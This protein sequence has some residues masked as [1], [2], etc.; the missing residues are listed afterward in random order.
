MKPEIALMIKKLKTEQINNE[1]I[2]IHIAYE[3]MNETEDIKKLHDGTW[4]DYLPSDAIEDVT[5]MLED[6]ES[7]EDIPDNESINEDV[8]DI[9]AEFD[10]VIE[11]RKN[12]DIQIA[13]MQNKYANLKEQLKKH[14]NPRPEKIRNIKLLLENNFEVT[15]SPNLDE[16]LNSNIWKLQNGKDPR[17]PKS[18]LEKA[19]QTKR[20]N[21]DEIPLILQR[22]HDVNWDKF[23]GVLTGASDRRNIMVIDFD[24]KRLPEEIKEL[25]LSYI[26]EYLNSEFIINMISEKQLYVETTMSGGYHFICSV[27]DFTERKSEKLIQYGDYEAI[28][29]IV[30]KSHH[31]VTYPSD[32]YSRLKNQLWEIIPIDPFEYDEL[33]QFTVNFFTEIDVNIHH[34]NVKSKS[35]ESKSNSNSSKSNKPQVTNDP[36]ESELWRYQ[37]RFQ[38]DNRDLEVLSRL[39]KECGYH[40]LPKE[41]PPYIRYTHSKSTDTNPNFAV[42]VEKH[43]IKNFSPN[44]TEFQ[45]DENVKS[46][47]ACWKLWKSLN[48]NSEL[49]EFYNYLKSEYEITLVLDSSEIFQ[50]ISQK[51]EIEDTYF[52]D[53]Y[54]SSTGYFQVSII[55]DDLELVQKS[56]NQIA[57]IVDITDGKELIK[58]KRELDRKQI[59]IP[60]LRRNYV[61]CINPPIEKYNFNPRKNEVDIFIP[62]TLKEKFQDNELWEWYLSDRFKEHKEFIKQWISAYCY[63]SEYEFLN[64]I[65]PQ[66]LSSLILLGERGVGKGTFANLIKDIF[67]VTHY[68]LLNS[69]KAG[70]KFDTWKGKKL[71]FIDESTEKTKNHSPKIYKTMKEVNGDAYVNMEAKGENQ[72]LIKNQCTFVIASN[73]PTPFFAVFS[74][75]PTNPDTNQFFVFEFDLSNEYNPKVVKQLRD[76]F[77]FYIKTELKDVFFN[78]VVPL[79][80]S[81]RNIRWVVSTPI[82]ERQKLLFASSKTV[83]D[84]LIEHMLRDIVNDKI[85]WFTKDDLITYGRYHEVK[86]DYILNL[87]IERQIV[88][89]IS[90]SRKIK[91]EFGTLKSQTVY[92][93]NSDTVNKLLLKYEIKVDP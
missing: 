6:V 13:E 31:C 58:M 79:I 17:E 88:K 16:L 78:S 69:E 70:S 9:D 10:R 52:Q 59:F 23:F 8:E 49:P 72:K 14:S 36:I 56:I 85:K 46:L 21:P 20:T 68:S 28:T 57:N 67:G 22:L 50:L 43:T 71:A 1:Q 29:E 27:D 73:D 51:R 33:I 62:T 18:P 81:D 87:L 19:W 40:K 84:H 92:V 64:D 54:C 37:K 53:F 32:G 41:D 3:S 2:E 83:N 90:E 63:Y 26:D 91:S 80:H 65:E 25:V 48:P 86:S 47:T 38:K 11:Y 60:K 61:Y 66:R 76:S 35:N 42:N 74:E 24:V 44:N 55:Q 89:R 7:N 4:I 5:E 75:I 15:I 12:I 45:Q 77:L 39:L 34:A 82:T 93:V 30:G